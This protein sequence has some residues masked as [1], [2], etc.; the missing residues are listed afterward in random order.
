MV[1][2]CLLAVLLLLPVVALGQPTT[3]NEG[4]FT[5]HSSNA[6]LFGTPIATGPDGAIYVCYI[7]VN[8]DTVLV[9][10]DP[11]TG[12]WSSPTVLEANTNDDDFHTQCSIAVD[13]DGFIHAVYNMHNTPW[14]YRRSASANDIS[15]MTFHGQDDGG[16]TGCTGQC[17]TDLY[18]EGIAAIPGNQITYPHF[19][20]TAD[21]TLYIAYRECFDCDASF[22]AR[23]WS[24]GLS[25]YNTTT[26]TWSRVGGIRPWATDAS[27]LPVGVRLWGSRTGRLHVSWLWCLHYNNVTHPSAPAGA[28][29]NQPNHPTYA[30]SD[31]GGG[32]WHRANGAALSLPISFA[33]SDQIVSPTWFDAA[34]AVGYWGGNTHIGAG[35]TDQPVVMTFPEVTNT[36]LGIR[37]GY[38]TYV[39][40]AWTPSTPLTLDFSPSIVYPDAQPAGV[41]TAVS[42]G[43]RL[44]RSLNGGQTWSITTL[45]TA[46]GA[47]SVAYDRGYLQQTGHLRLY[48]NNASTGLL[49]IWTVQFPETQQTFYVNTTGNDSNNCLAPWAACATL[50][51]AV[52]LAACGD[53][54]TVLPGTYFQRLSTTK[55]CT[56]TT[57]L[58]IQGTRGVGGSFA[59]RLDG[60]TAASGWTSAAASCGS[61][62][63][64]RIT[65]PGFTPRH[66]YAT[67]QR[68]SV[69]RIHQSGNLTGP[70]C[71]GCSGTGFTVLGRSPTST[72]DWGV[73]TVNYW[74]GVEALWG[75]EGGFTYARFRNGEDP[76]TLSVRVAPSGGTIDLNGADYITI[77]DLQIEGGQYQVEMRTTAT[78][79][80]IDDVDAR[81]GEAVIAITDS[82]TNTVQDSLLH[83][84]YIGSVAGYTQTPYL[85]GGWDSSTQAR[86]I[87]GSIY[88]VNKFD[89][90][91]TR[92]GHPG[93]LVQQGSSGNIL[94]RNTIPLSSVG[95][96]L[97]TSTTTQVLQNDIR[98]CSSECI[99]FVD[100]TSAT[101]DQNTLVDGEH[102]LRIQQANLNGRTLYYSRNFHYQSGPSDKHINFSFDTGTGT[103][104]SVYWMY[105]N[106]YT[107]TGWSHDAG[108]GS[109][110]WG[111]CVRIVNEVVSVSGAG[112]TRGVSST[113]WHGNIGV[114]AYNWTG[115]ASSG[116]PSGFING[117][118]CT[119][120]FG[121]NL[122][123][124]T[125][126]WPQTPMPDFVLPDG[127]AATNSALRL[128]QNFTLGSTLYPP[129]PT[130]S[131]AYYG[132]T[133]P[134]RGAY[135]GTESEPPPPPEP[136][137]SQ[138]QCGCYQVDI[139]ESSTEGLRPIPCA[140]KPGGRIRVVCNVGVTGADVTTSLGFYASDSGGS[141][142]K[143]ANALG[144][145][146]LGIGPDTQM[147][148]PGVT[149]RLTM[150]GQTY[151]NCCR[152][153][154][155]TDGAQACVLSAS[156][157]GERTECGVTLHTAAGATP[158]QTSTLWLRHDDGTPLTTETPVT[159]TII[160]AGG[161]GM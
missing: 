20:Q 120:F 67:S 154:Q 148:L 58:T 44:H 62:L 141:A 18:G 45:D 103:T 37:R 79:N 27:R 137:L 56:S 17:E 111:P 77:K 114:Y 47:F 94:Q 14:Q 138:L 26:Q 136:V 19:G 126:I 91:D 15:T 83:P 155:S 131:A 153:R 1:V 99:W 150:D 124:I 86:R 52:D 147:G 8:L 93:I 104:N 55:S 40:G 108:Q 95:I 134:H 59:T 90:G 25:L 72:I 60:S 63:C 41:W 105:H 48:A 129:L 121:N 122:S 127:H 113:S 84:W 123:S 144:G 30:Y 110:G 146:R 68:L 117:Q 81:G 159:V 149:P 97:A 125:P 156:G 46:R 100:A 32:T 43:L 36:S 152:W 49:V 119:G 80:L 143:L 42:G 50:Q 85:P 96:E 139:P 70:A 28:C 65:N 74:D 89:V 132:D 64:F 24:A 21:G 57:R 29:L 4:E 133:T 33:A 78:N 115:E 35:P 151:D 102:L 87:A 75:E 73:G 22:F 2:I 38:V 6:P 112:G 54:V 10:K 157:V 9:R 101:I 82:D 92:E 106:T 13:T 76:D 160:Q 23:Q 12:T 7:D 140:V 31:D 98:N 53:T 130:I 3:T 145:N 11:G 118:G 158:G 161:E 88:Q 39:N 135:Q 66:L 109:V 128:D 107:G 116:A 61:A 69:W 34:G 142:Y 5:T 16:T 51:H 71:S